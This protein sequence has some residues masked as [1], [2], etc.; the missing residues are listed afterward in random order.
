MT[1]SLPFRVLSS[2]FPILSALLQGHNSNSDIPKC[3]ALLL[4][5]Q[6]PCKDATEVGNT[7]S[8]PTKVGNIWCKPIC[9]HGT[10][11]K[12][13]VLRVFFFDLEVLSSFSDG[14]KNN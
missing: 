6:G 12:T 3:T 7:V 13:T 10:Y 8:P 14:K 9:H 11:S 1:L 4:L 2:H 5:S